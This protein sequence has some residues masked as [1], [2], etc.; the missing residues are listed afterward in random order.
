M[1]IESSV[2]L[3]DLYSFTQTSLDF[4]V[5]I[6]EEMPG[7]D[8]YLLA[9]SMGWAAFH[10]KRGLEDPWEP[11]KK[12]EIGSLFDVAWKGK[13]LLKALENL[14]PSAREAI[15]GE[16]WHLVPFKETETWRFL[17]TLAS[18]VSIYG[19]WMEEV[20][21]KPGKPGVTLGEKDLLC[22]CAGM[23]CS[24]IEGK[25]WQ[26]YSKLPM[27]DTTCILLVPKLARE[28]HFMTTGAREP[29][30]FRKA[31]REMCANPDEFSI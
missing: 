24:Q 8:P 18:R 20:E 6:T 23:L 29:Q 7:L 11:N 14:G 1:P 16:M 21:S 12:A 10:Y 19:H 9:Q 27:M 31:W 17:S 2:T 15:I 4:A 30:K 13:E 25:P 5:K 22:Q 28:I 26:L 3:D